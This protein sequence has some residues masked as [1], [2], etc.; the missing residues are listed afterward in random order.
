MTRNQKIIK[1]ITAIIF[2]LA[3]IGFQNKAVA[4]VTYAT[5]HG[6]VTDTS[7]AIIPNASVVALN[8]S[9]GIKT[10]VTTD[11]RGYY[12]LPQLQIGG[13]YT[14]SIDAQGF[15]HYEE[16]GLT[17][18]LN[19][20]REVNA[21]L[22]IGGAAQTIQVQA[23]AVQVETADTQLKQV[24]S[25]QQIE[26]LPLLG[27]DASQLQKLQPGTVE[28]SDRFGTY[29]ANG[30]QTSNNS[31]LLNGADDNDY[32][33][34]SEG[35]I[36][37][38]DALAEEN[39]VAST[40]NPEFSRNGGAIINQT[41]KNGT[42]SFHGSAFWF[43]R[44]TFLNNGN[45]FSLPGQRPP[46]HQ[47]LYGATLGGPV[48]KNRLFF[49]LAYQG[50]RNSTGT[51]TQTPVLSPAALSGDF[52]NDFNSKTG[53]LNSAGLSTN[54]IPFAIPGCVAGAT[55]WATCFP[56]GTVSIA[57][58]AFNPLAVKLMNQYV[59]SSNVQQGSSY[60]YNFNTSDTGAAD[61]GVIRA[62]YHISD[63]DSIWGSS[64]FQS[65]PTTFTLPFGG[66]TLPGF[67]MTNS[68]H[69]KIFSASYT[70]TFATSAL[71][72]LHAGY[73]RLN[74]PS[75]S[76]AKIISP[77]AYGFNINPQIGESSL[78]YMSVGGYFTLGFSFEG[79][80]PRKDTNLS[81][82][83]TFTK[84][85]GNHS[86]KF[87]VQLEQFRVSN[88]FAVD[89]NGNYTYSGSGLYSS[90]DTALDFLLGIP[91]GYTQGS[92]G[93]IDAMSHEYY[94][95]AQDS[96]KV[97]ND[98]TLNYGLA[99]DTETPTTNAQ[100]KG[101]GIVCWQNTSTQSAILPGG[102]PGLFYPGDPG[103]NRAGGPTPKYN[104]FGP[105][106]GIAW[107][108]STGPSML[109][110]PSGSHDLAV[111]A[112]FGLYYNRDQ[113]EGSLQ[114]V[115]NPPFFYI[116]NGVKDLGSQYSP[117]FA[118]PFAD[119]AGNGAKNNPFPYPIP[120]AGSTV[121]WSP[122]FNLSLNSFDRNYAVPYI[123]NFNLNVQ[124]SL[125]S[126][127][128]LQIG[129]VGSLGRKLIRWYEAD[130]ITPSGHAACLADP[131][132]SSNGAFI[133]LLYP[134][135][136][137]QPA[138]SPSGNP[139]YTSVARQ[140]T[141][142]ASS[143]HS[144]QVSL[145][146]GPTHGLYLTLAY[147]YSH[148]LDNSSGYESA[149]G[150]VNNG[151]D[152]E[153]ALI[154]TPGFDYLNYGDSDYDARHRFVAGYNYEIPLLRS[155]KGQPIVKELLG[156][157]HFTGITA[158]QTGNPVTVQQLNAFSSL[159][160]DT[161]SYFGCG[162]VP[163]TSSFRIKS[164]NPRAPGNL[165]FNPNVFSPAP[166]GTYG[167]VKRNFFHGPGFNYSNLEIYKNFP[168][169]GDGTRYLQLRLEAYNAFNHANFAQPQ[170][171][172]NAGPA[173]GQIT[174][175]IAPSPASEDPQPARSVQLAAKFYF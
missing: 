137:T 119:I 86:L 108:P 17:L 104:G 83:D 173:F 78:P 118:N 8:T 46:F 57:T 7:G 170:G 47:N 155:M 136:A 153:K 166:L 52:T 94:A 100:F 19:D 151:F 20:N 93:F 80:Q 144:F 141:N 90:G 30:S 58:S 88:P 64:I 128:V 107:S 149:S 21:Q 91:D 13:P 138:L 28:A 65:S 89:N 164:L 121:D 73:Y 81:G 129:Y 125:P 38:P 32:S 16:A 131:V 98:V 157:W 4:Q 22:Q 31:Y 161:F 12:T 15:Q 127:M 25:S 27:R 117:A 110:G 167:N 76:P 113:E 159:W 105:R 63:K 130:P 95:F 24:V 101:L 6:T 142:G 97:S 14:I 42:N 160:C 133:H 2:L 116:S 79:P 10:T 152:N 154:T 145:I 92:G 134:Q 87:G 123:Y 165:W 112:G 11:G 96:W 150:G 9:T 168:F 82:G 139:W 34:Q 140:T 18:H 75:V 124:R 126:N 39:I 43:Y 115:G 174:S 122:Y 72:E 85:I 67:E 45:Y 71:N 172:F 69:F 50:F 175:V 103:C 60:L 48:I 23:A 77:S 135:Y 29:S 70:H 36:I 5:V 3:G 49:F 106:I 99:W 148:A 35:L 163:N 120:T 74:Y 26:Q 132:C 111:R 54:P 40:L 33:L 59:P 41:I 156:G 84:I 37:N 53:A 162:D 158:L 147:T 171:N 66:S 169:N 61:Q 62:D 44:D 114:N 68:E 146:K 1:P 56:D 143:Y 109:V 102:P 51:T 55:T